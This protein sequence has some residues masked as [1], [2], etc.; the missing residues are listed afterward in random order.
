MKD[1]VQQT[2]AEPT[3]ISSRSI[4]CVAAAAQ[5]AVQRLSISDVRRLRAAT[6]QG[7]SAER[8]S[9]YFRLNKTCTEVLIE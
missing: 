1:H 2:F 3:I 7:A 8:T 4:N 5:R 6:V 9:N